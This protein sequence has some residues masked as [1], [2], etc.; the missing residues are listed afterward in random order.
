MRSER[1][2]QFCKAAFTYPPENSS[3]KLIDG[4]SAKYNE[5]DY[6][7]ATR[8]IYKIFKELCQPPVPGDTPDPSAT[9]SRQPT[10]WTSAEHLWE[11]ILMYGDKVLLGEC[12]YD[13]H[14]KYLLCQRGSNSK[15]F[16]LHGID[17]EA[18]A[19]QSYGYRPIGGE[20]PSSRDKD[21]P[22]LTR[23]VKN[24][25]KIISPMTPPSETLTAQQVIDLIV[26]NGSQPMRFLA[27]SG[28]PG[29]AMGREVNKRWPLPVWI[30]VDTRQ[31]EWEPDR[32]QLSSYPNI[33]GDNYQVE[34][35]KI[36][37]NTDTCWSSTWNT[38]AFALYKESAESTTEQSAES[39]TEQSTE[40]QQPQLMTVYVPFDKTVKDAIDSE[41]RAIADKYINDWGIEKYLAG[42]LEDKMKEVM[43]E[44]RPVYIKMPQG[45][46]DKPV[47]W[48]LHDKFNDILFLAKIE[49]QV[50][51]V[52]P[53][54]TGKTTTAHQVADALSL[55][56]GFISC[57]GGMS[58]AA[59]T[60]RMLFDGTY[61]PT[62]FVKC[63]ENGGVFLLDE[64]DAADSNTLL[65]INS[66]LA[67]GHLSLSNRKDNSIATRHENFICICAANTYGSGSFDY[68]GRNILDKAFLD[69]FAASKVFMGYDEKLEA[70]LSVWH[71]E[72]LEFFQS[73]RKK[74]ETGGI[75]EIVSTRAIASAVRQ[76]KAWAKFTDI[77]KRFF[78]SWS[79]DNLAKI[80]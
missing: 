3:E 19:E 62:D 51:I 53:A 61:V 60:G 37:N 54:G 72:I 23:L 39:T 71:E 38:A 32:Q 27:V 6:D 44:L 12:E 57:T 36:F 1:T 46:E 24:I 26:V 55:N 43:K 14:I 34:N 10:T 8:L 74:I 5:W 66:A 73:V 22:A 11:N 25:F 28:I 16:N 59:L 56:F 45:T 70:A 49:K 68:A 15:I 30:W 20:W 64:V 18:L 35:K 33:I 29:G 4:N 41:T 67:N 80:K 78:L 69:R 76:T 21:Y 75:R 9:Q 63:Y 48:L 58:E 2:I 7:A 79:K 65:I 31:S 13:V 42:S 50:M 17:K 47:E 52:G 40:P 77:K